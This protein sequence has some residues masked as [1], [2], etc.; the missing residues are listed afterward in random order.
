MKR[1][2][3]LHPLSE[4]HHHA[5][6]QVLNIRRAEETPETERSAALERAGHS[7]LEHW[8]MTGRKHFREEEEVLL[9]A[10]SRHTELSEDS[11]VMRMLAQHAMIRAGMEQLE[12]LLSSKQPADTEVIA[13]GKLLHDHVRLEE[14]NLFPRIEAELSEEEL[15]ALGQKFTRLHGVQKE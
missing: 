1:H 4:H 6:V 2:R 13:I 7:L 5:L 3:S 11:T 10:F 15:L 14:D 9:P 12:T 8:K